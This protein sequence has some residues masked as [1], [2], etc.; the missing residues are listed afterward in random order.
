MLSVGFACC[1]LAEDEDRTGGGSGERPGFDL[2]DQPIGP[3]QRIA[4]PFAHTDDEPAAA[5]A[6]QYAARQIAFV[7][8]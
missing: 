4:F 3:E 7:Q 6:K 2:L 1:G 5:V 8:P